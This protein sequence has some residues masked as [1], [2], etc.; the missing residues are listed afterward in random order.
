[1]MVL[2]DT[3]DSPTPSLTT[4]H[5]LSPR[6]IVAKV[7]TFVMPSFQGEVMSIKIY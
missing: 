5:T 2:K 3:A 7:L 4:N 1:M 6:A